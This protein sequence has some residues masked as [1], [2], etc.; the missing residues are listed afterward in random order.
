MPALTRLGLFGLFRSPPLKNMPAP[1]TATV[2]ATLTTAQL[3]GQIL[4]VDQGSGGT[5]TLTTS[6]G[7]QIEAAVPGPL[8]DGDYFDL[9]VINEEKDA[10]GNMV[11]AMGVGVTLIGNNDVEEEDAVSNSSSA[12]FRFRRTAANTWDCMRLA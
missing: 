3:F 12:H 5:T 9:F 4:R 8:T 1:K 2:T 10:G 11:L 6:T 7:T